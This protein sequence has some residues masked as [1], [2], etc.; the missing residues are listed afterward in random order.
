MIYLVKDWLARHKGV[1]QHLGERFTDIADWVSSAMGTP[2]NIILWLILVLGWTLVFAIHPALQNAN[3]LPSWF[4]SQVYNFPL[5]L[6]TTVAELFIGFLVAAASNR[7]E[8]RN[9]Q[10]MLRLDRM[11]KQMLRMEKEHGNE[12]QSLQEVIA[13]QHVLITELHTH[14]TCLGHTTIGD[15]TPPKP[16][17]APASAAAAKPRSHHK[18]KPTQ[19]KAA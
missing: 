1:T 13:E 4:T 14:V 3:F 15:P 11:E 8:R 2:T 9:H 17:S 16:P 12:L 5:N 6:I 18:A 10:Q 19:E 7:I